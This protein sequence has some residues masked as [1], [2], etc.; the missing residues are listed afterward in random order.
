[1]SNLDAIRGRQTL[2]FMTNTSGGQ[3]VDG[4]VVIYDTGA[5]ESFTTTTTPN[6]NDKQVGVAQELIY[7]GSN[8]RVLVAG[9]APKVNVN[10]SNVS[11]GNRGYFLFTSQVA[12]TA[13]YAAAR[14]SG[15]F[16][17]LIKSGTTPS[18]LVA[19]MS[20]PN[21]LTN[22]LTTTGDIIYSSSGTTAA[23]LGIGSSTQ[24]LTVTG[25]VPVW[26]AAGSATNLQSASYKRTAG[27][28]TTTS[29]TFVDVDS[30]NFSLTFTTG[31]RRV[32]LGLV[33][34]CASSGTNSSVVFDVTVDGARQGGT[35]WG[36]QRTQ[37]YTAT[38]VVDCSFV[39]VTDA[40]SAASH[41]FKL[42]WRASA[43]TATLFGSDPYCQF[44]AVELY[45]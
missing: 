12:K 32:M 21:V 29:T 38:A 1:M 35:S 36:M 14:G 31:A 17:Q 27:D 41:T 42:Q 40:L 5:D 7:N 26:A 4:D 43:D 15:A 37:I 24:V 28:Y 45:A 25:G 20:D 39:F 6:T 11:T 30:T 18:A 2:A 13:R 22:P 23:R 16:G 34:S 10:G 19:Q 8:G 44:Y 3:V 9:Y 33:G